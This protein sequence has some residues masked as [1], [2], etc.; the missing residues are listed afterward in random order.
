M[1]TIRVQ[2]SEEVE[3]SFV[4]SGRRALHEEEMRPYRDAVA[5]RQPERAGEV[6][7]GYQDDGA[8]REP[9]VPQKP[10]GRPCG[11]EKEEPSKKR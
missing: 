5:Q 1:P 11:A 4:P 8:E 6:E 7:V 10:P 3:R 2:T 9:D